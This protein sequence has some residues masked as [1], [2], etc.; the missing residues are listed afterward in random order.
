LLATAGNSAR[1]VQVHD[2]V[3][4]KVPGSTFTLLLVRKNEGIFQVF[5]GSYERLTRMLSASSVI[6][7]SSVWAG[8]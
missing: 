2:E 5:H 6:V 3:K 1:I 7:K 8:S 4:L